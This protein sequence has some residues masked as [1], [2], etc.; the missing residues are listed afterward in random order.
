MK[1]R[2]K[3]IIL[4]LLGIASVVSGYSYSMNDK[5][6]GTEELLL[7]E[8]SEKHQKFQES[9][10]SVDT[11]PKEMFWDFNGW[12]DYDG[13]VVADPIKRGVTGGALWI[14]VEGEKSGKDMESWAYQVWGSNPKYD[15][16]SPQKL[17]V[18]AEKYNIIQMRIRNLSPETDGLIFW[19][20]RDDSES[21]AGQAHFSM[22]PDYPEWQEVTC[23]LPDSWRGTIDQIRIRPAQMWMRGDIW[24]DWIG[25]GHGEPEEKLPRPGLCSEKVVPEI[26][27]PGISQEDFRQAF[28]VLD[29]CLVTDVPLKGFHFPFL[30]PGGKYGQSW[31]QLDASLNIAGAKWVNQALVENMMRGF[32]GVQEQNPDGRIDLWG[33]SPM[34]GMQGN[35]SSLPR[36]FEAAFDVATRTRDQSLQHLILEIMKKYLTYWFSPVKRDS[37]SGLITAVFEE[38]FS[39]KSFGDRNARPGTLAPVDLN[40]AVAVGCYNTSRLAR[41]LGNTED[42][43][44]YSLLFEQLSAAINTH[45][46]N[47]E[48]KGFYNYDVRENKQK[49]RLI[50]T[51]FDPMRL[52]IAPEERIEKMIPTL[53]NPDIFNWGTRPL[54]SIAKTDPDF[55]EATGTYD[56]TAW[57]GDVWTLRNM[58]IVAG[59]EDAGKHD[60]AAELNWATIK[61]FNNNYSEYIAPGTGSG[62]G[63]KRYGWT[64]SQ[65][66]QG[67]IEHLFGIQ[68][69]HFESRL[70]IF[71]HIPEELKG[72]VISIR[73]LSIPGSND[74]RL[75]LTVD[76][77]SS[78]KVQIQIEFDGLVPEG[79][80]CVMLPDSGGKKFRVQNGKNSMPPPSEIIQDKKNCAG[81]DIPFQNSI[82]LNFE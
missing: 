43:K 42:G 81:I 77:T 3:H 10:P 38:S 32:A 27:L 4:L 82:H 34:R 9:L 14:S 2:K 60:L 45:L 29:E 17:N 44:M 76:C 70:Y 20:T 6:P 61:M 53:L 52:G 7:Y 72:Q 78:E 49:D 21:D 63:V 54:T 8:L 65:Y 57:F 36:F 25:I 40:V 64:A 55:V 39:D 59:L 35:V 50:C 15:I 22:K 28:V 47:E 31:W 62:E 67:I 33:G 66:V 30:A 79:W 18:T 48:K 5:S 26:R 71:P 1:K 24:I 51:T 58:F 73:R 11:F 56:G 12:N 13:W 41:Y 68:Y 19:R 16:V 23:Y 80:V 75:N 37:E 74:L 69:N 46:W